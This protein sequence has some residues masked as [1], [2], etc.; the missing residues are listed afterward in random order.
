[1]KNRREQDLRTSPSHIKDCEPLLYSIVNSLPSMIGYWDKDLHC[2]FANNAY[3]FWFDKH[4]KEII[5]MTFKEL[6]GEKI[7]TDNTPY[8]RKVLAGE[9]QHFEKTLKK[10]NGKL[11]HIIGHYIPDFDAQGHVQGFSILANEV[12]D[13]K[14]TEAQ[15]KLAACVFE[16]TLDG[17]LITDSNGL[18]LSVNPAFI[19]ITGYSEAEVLN[20]NPRI[21][22]SNRHDAAFYAAMWEDIKTK[23]QW[24]GKVWN[25]RKNG[26][27]YLERMTISMVRNGDGEAIRYVSVF[28]DITAL[29][30]KDEYIKHLAFHDA[31]TNLPNRTA[32]IKTID[33]K[34]ENLYH[35]TYNFALMFLD[36]D[37]FKKVN[38]HYGHD[39][40][41]KLLQEIAKRLLSLVRQSDTIARVGGDEFIF[42]LNNPKGKEEIKHVAQRIID[43]LNQPIIIEEAHLQ[44]GTSIGIALSPQHGHTSDMLIKNAD[45]AMYTAKSR[46]ENNLSF[47]SN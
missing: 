39:I 46:G 18:I 4:P 28:S 36:L 47:F 14:E 16:N 43:S 38:D 32:L 17:V 42:I 19:E 2:H 30:H 1:M 44:V 20:Q 24:K 33:Q 35:D 22:K 26:D 3:T 6:A 9:A 13:L 45:T 8:I 37:G 25:R 7:F 41:D 15:L 5:G 34:L 29:W 21:L 12:T 23:G 40:G 31:L 11:G 10:A 27:L